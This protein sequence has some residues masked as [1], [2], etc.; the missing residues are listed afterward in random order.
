MLADK[1]FTT[2]LK[3]LKTLENYES[4]MG[5]YENLLNEISC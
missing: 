3:E 2:I 4:K 1:Q 5:L